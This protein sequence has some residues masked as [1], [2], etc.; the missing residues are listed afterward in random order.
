MRAEDFPWNP[1]EQL[2]DRCCYFFRLFDPLWICQGVILGE[3]LA[4]Q[5]HV[6][7]CMQIHFLLIR[8]S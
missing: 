8:T 6:P 1:P 5:T 3:S 7:S 4:T 2:G